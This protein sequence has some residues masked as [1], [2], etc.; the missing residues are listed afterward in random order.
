MAVEQLYGW[1]PNPA[2]VESYLNA[3]DNKYPVFTASGAQLKREYEKKDTNLALGIVACNPNWQRGAQ[4]IGDC[5]SWGLELAGTALVAKQC[6]RTGNKKMFCEVATEPLYGGSRVE[7]YG[8]KYGS[9]ED[10]A[11]GAKAAEFARRYGMHLRK[12]HS[13]ETGNPEHDLRKYDAKRAKQWGYYGCG[14]QRDG[15]KLD[16]LAKNMPAK[17]TTLVTCFD[18]VAAAIAGAKCPVTIA[19]NYGSS[20]KRDKW[21]QCKWDGSWNHQMVLLAV[22]FGPRP[23]A[24]CFQSWG[25]MVASGGEDPNESDFGKYKFMSGCSWWIPAS[26]IDRICKQGDS[27][28][29]GDI[30][31]WK[32]DTF[33]YSQNFGLVE[34]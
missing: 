28:A 8:I 20:M 13:K 1:S 17:T 26:D 6:L 2:A 5:V 12:D 29:I 11:N 16:L 14:G 21:G 3:P 19:S 18:D 31:G 15:G 22:R 32:I 27:H 34:G 23:G 10:G 30:E 9:W 24:R 4:G 33:D 25:P 7:V